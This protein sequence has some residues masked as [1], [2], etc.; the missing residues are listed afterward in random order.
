MTMDSERGSLGCDIVVAKTLT[1]AT[2]NDC[3]WCRQ[4][5]QC[6]CIDWRDIRIKKLILPCDEVIKH[7]AFYAGLAMASKATGK[8]R[9]EFI[10]YMTKI[11]YG[12]IYKFFEADGVTE[13]KLLLCSIY[14]AFNDDE[15]FR[16]VSD[17]METTS[18]TRKIKASDNLLPRLKLITYT[19]MIVDFG[20]IKQLEI[21][22]LEE[23]RKKKTSRV[24]M[25]WCASF[26]EKN[27]RYDLQVFNNDEAEVTIYEND[28]VKKHVRLSDAPDKWDIDVVRKLN[29]LF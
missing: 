19:F 23:I 28:K 25:I 15:D 29:L 1:H 6:K 20:L 2:K 21:Q 24:Q 9:R 17:F 22:V 8:S 10:S 4:E 3:W 11:L 7:P 27:L 26:T 5:P 14:S 13:F 12:N 18:E 16:W